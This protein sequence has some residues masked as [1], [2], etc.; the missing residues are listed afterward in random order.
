MTG[1]AF[2]L[3]YFIDYI[4][5]QSLSLIFM[6][7]GT[8]NFRMLPIQL[9]CCP[10]VV[11]ILYFPETGKVAAHTIRSAFLL[12]LPLMDIGMTLCAVPGKTGKLLS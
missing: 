3:L 4:G 12:K 2:C 11:K 7:S 1:F 10:V 5:V 9:K 6:A 8:V